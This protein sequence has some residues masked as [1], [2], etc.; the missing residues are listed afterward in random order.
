[1]Q[2]ALYAHVA[3][4]RLDGDVVD[5]Q[6]HFPTR[7]GQNQSFRFDRER[8]DRVYGLLDHMLDGAAAGYFVPTNEPSDCTFCDFREI[9]RVREGGYGKSVSPL[10][11]WSKEQTNTG[12]WPAFGHL[13][14]TRNYED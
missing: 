5:G 14:K 8:L 3:D 4:T 12:L 2:H 13:K 7:R 10:A 9:C 1:L 11:D 6:Y